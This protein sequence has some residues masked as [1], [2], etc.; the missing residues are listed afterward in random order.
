MAYTR[1]RV[2]VAGTGFAGYHCLRMLQRRL[3]ESE[4]ELVAVNPADYMLYV[5]LLPEVTG[6]ILDPRRVAVPLRTK[7]PRARLILGS[8]TGVDIKSHKCTVV[9]V[10]GRP[11][12]LEW[13]RIVLTAGS[14]TRLM[15][16]PGVAEYAK[17]FKTIA[18]AVYLRDH[19]LRQLELAEHAETPA[20]REARMT[21]VVV[22]AGYTG[23]ELV[24]QGQL[25]TRA[26]LRH[27][28]SPEAADARWLL[29]DLAP[30]VLPGM[31]ERLSGPALRVL[32]KRGVDVRLETTISEVDKTCV[33]LTDGS[34]IPT[35]TVV[36]CVGVRPDPL[37]EPLGL[38]TT[39]GRLDV[40]EWLTV[41][42]CE[43]VYAAGDVAAAPN[44]RK[45][46]EIAPMTAQHAQRQGRIAGI[47]V[48]ASFGHGLRMP[49]RHR[50]RGFLVDLGGA[51]AV[52]DPLHIPVSGWPAK[53]LTRTH[54]LM[55]IP[56][57]GIRV[58]TDWCTE[59]L[60]PRQI[61]HFGLI[62]ESGITLTNE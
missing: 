32:R 58:F 12:T 50:D 14:V 2:V 33:R 56:A 30:R 5:P 51:Q 29:V 11:S 57:N 35:R 25:L 36:W 60:T 39:N 7:L 43:D 59:L 6:G 4:V 52:G 3:P 38:P 31:S 10:E 21:F 54:H 23:T 41:P 18:E 40:D 27:R 16:I 46:G 17:G 13:D 48:A 37:V 8:V 61:V 19:I 55:S 9:D 53:A 42:G 24:A 15:S 47:N 22:G 34:E 44:M 49:Y 28:R 26:A 45:P 20:E 62:P 1:S